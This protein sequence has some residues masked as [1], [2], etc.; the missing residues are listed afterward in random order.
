MKSN[1]LLIPALLL[2]AVLCG[3]QSE[4]KLVTNTY[5]NIPD[6]ES[7]R[8]CKYDTSAV[9]AF[10]PK[11]KSQ[12]DGRLRAGLEALG[13]TFVDLESKDNAVFKR[14][15]YVLSIPASF[16]TERVY[17]EGLIYGGK[18]GVLVREP[19]VDPSVKPQE[20]RM[21]TAFSRV[22]IGKAETEK[23]RAAAI[24]HYRKTG[25]S[26]AFAENEPRDRA[27]NQ[28]ADNMLLN[29]EFRKALEKKGKI[30]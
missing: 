4:P 9:L 12:V 10:D 18:C 15:D 3:C 29:P 19:Q 16:H 5:F 1:N 30:R 14:P 17:L 22:I 6:Y 26:G 8:G 20:P 11:F 24:E 2:F 28:A 7:Y 23:L 13:Y 21:F 27:I 25:K